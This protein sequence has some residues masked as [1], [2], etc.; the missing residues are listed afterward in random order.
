MAHTDSN[1]DSTAMLLRL[2]FENGHYCIA[3]VVIQCFAG[4]LFW[5]QHFEQQHNQSNGFGHKFF[6]SLN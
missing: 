6:V 2:N 5:R 1:K 3:V 4:G